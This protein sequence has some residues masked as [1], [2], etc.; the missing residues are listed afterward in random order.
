M[1]KYSGSDVDFSIGANAYLNAVS[2]YDSTGSWKKYLLAQKEID[3]S[4]YAAQYALIYDSSV[5]KYKLHM[6]D[7]NGIWICSFTAD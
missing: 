4:V 7:A 3:N 5:K 6:Y 2:L 1:K